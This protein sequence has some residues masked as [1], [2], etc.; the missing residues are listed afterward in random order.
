M[1]FQVEGTRV[2]SLWVDGRWVDEVSMAKL[3]D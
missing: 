3:L 1:G 2:H